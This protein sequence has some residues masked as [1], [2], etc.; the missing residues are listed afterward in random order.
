MATYDDTQEQLSYID[1]ISQRLHR[2]DY[3]F[4]YAVVVVVW[5][6]FLLAYIPGIYSDW[7]NG[8]RLSGLNLW[9]PRVG[10]LVATLISYVGLYLFWGNSTPEE[11]S[12]DLGITVLFIIASLLIFAW[13]VALYQAENIALATWIACALFV[14]EFWLFI[15]I[16]N[17]K[18][19]AA[20]FLIPLLFMYFYLI[21]SM[22]QL[23]R[24]NNVPL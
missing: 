19:I 9:I 6:L 20:L 3:L 7:Y 16:W 1:R 12:R 8:L 4:V 5:I 2:A 17:L 24:L 15:Y 23:A 21:Y 11:M 13:A 18:P 10:W 14:Y 22:I